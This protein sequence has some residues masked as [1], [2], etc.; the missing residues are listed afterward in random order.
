M[1]PLIHTILLLTLFSLVSAGAFT[2]TMR[3]NADPYLNIRSKATTSS[4]IVAKAPNH[5][6]VE[7]V[8]AGQTIDS[9]GERYG[10]WYK[11]KFEGKTGYAFSLFLLDTWPESDFDEEP[12]Y[13]YISVDYAYDPPGVQEELN[14]YGVI[15]TEDEGK[16]QGPDHDE[17]GGTHSRHPPVAGKYSATR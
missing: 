10:Y 12:Y 7:I 11:V 17:P 6:L 8:E 14:Y 5:S 15:E 16:C 2:Q 13:N 3:V 9:V 1:K 4:K